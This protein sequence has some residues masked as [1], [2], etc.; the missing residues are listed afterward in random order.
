MQEGN[1]KV[2]EN[3]GNIHS[4]KNRKKFIC[5]YFWPLDKFCQV[6]IFQ[7]PDDGTRLYGTFHFSYS[8]KNLWFD[9]QKSCPFIFSP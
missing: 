7:M 2:G 6:N 3:E 8:S 5:E 4:Y 9:L 1:N